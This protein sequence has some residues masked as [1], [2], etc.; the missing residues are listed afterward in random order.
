MARDASK[1]PLSMT[2]AD[3]CF[4]RQRPPEAY[5]A[6]LKQLGFAAAELVAPEHF[7]LA[8]AAELPILNIGGNSLEK[9]LN[10]PALHDQAF[11]EI[12]RAMATAAEHRIQ[13]VIVFAGNRFGPSDEEGVA[14]CA[15]VLKQLAPLAQRYGVTLTLEV[16]CQQNHPGYQADNGAFA[17]SVV[18]RVGSPRVKALYD[19]YHMHRMGEAVADQVVAHLPLIAHLHVAG[20]PRRNY[21]GSGQEI[22]YAEVVRRVHGAGYR[23]HWGME[24]MPEGD[25]LTELAAARDLLAGFLA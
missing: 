21:P 23:G 7:G 25:P 6:A 9:P 13:Q 15:A 18:E 1:S 11:A 19:I 24:F 22:A 5:Y 10:N 17:F 8:A 12:S 4:L 20:A 3:W 16:F 2:A 14:Q